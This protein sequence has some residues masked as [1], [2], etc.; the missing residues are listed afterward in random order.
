MYEYDPILDT[1]TSR[2]NFGGAVRYG[3]AAFVIGTTGYVGCGRANSNVY[4]DWWK[5]TDPLLSISEANVNAAIE[6]YPNPVSTE[7]VIHI[8]NNNATAHFTFEVFNL[9]GKR[10]CKTGI[11]NDYVFS[12]EGLSSGTYIYKISD[13]GNVIGTG[14]LLIL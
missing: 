13:K 4:G 7:C 11:S 2:P 6:V 9:D 3:P 12:R 1:W 8:V 10:V 14:K 5:Y